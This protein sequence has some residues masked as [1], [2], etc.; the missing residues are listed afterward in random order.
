MHSRHVCSL[1]LCGLIVLSQALAQSV[2]TTIAGTDWLFP[3]NGLPA[4]NA[5]LSGSLGLD[6]AVDRNGNLYIAD[7]GNGE[8]MKVGSN[9]IL[10]V[11]A[12]TGIFGATG[13]GG[14]AI[15]AALVD[16]N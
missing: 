2:I 7:L 5:P 4:I 9:G 12:G 6:I 16:A 1:V 10:S 8:V 14:L 11:I 15:S 3:G 13:D